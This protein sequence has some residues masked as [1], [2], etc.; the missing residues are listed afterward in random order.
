M[1]ERQQRARHRLFPDNEALVRACQRGDAVAWSEI[2]DRYERLVY[3]VPLKEGLTID[4]AADVAQE[5]FATLMISLH[6]IRQPDRLGWW[7]MTVARRLSWRERHRDGRAEIDVTSIDL[8]GDADVGEESVTVQWV[9]DAIQSLA[10][11]CRA[12]VVSLFFDPA[13]PS[14]AEI[15]VRLGR[16]LGSVGPLRARCLDRL[17]NVLE[18]TP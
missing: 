18:G 8:E 13:E 15:A 5:T 2:V 17:K 14:Y 1:I 16:P 9:F 7:L 12:L 3:A 6:Q 11:P 10:E 4:E